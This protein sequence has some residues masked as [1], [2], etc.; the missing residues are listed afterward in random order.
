MIQSIAVIFIVAGLAYIWGSRGFFSS[1]LHMVCVI[2]A[3]AIAYGL[4]ETIA[5]A[6]LDA[7]VPWMVELAW[8]AGL[9]LPFAVSLAVLRLAVDKLV[10][11]NCDLDG[12]PNLIG[13]M[14]CG[15]ITGTITA[16][17]LLT[18]VNFF[19]INPTLMGFTQVRQEP[20][21]SPVINDR[22]LFP[23][24]KITAWVY[25]YAAEA[26]L[27]TETPLNKWRPNVTVDGALLRTNFNSGGSKHTLTTKSYS[28]ARRFT[29][30]KEA[31]IPVSDLLSD[32]FS[33]TPPKASTF[34]GEDIPV[35]S[36]DYYIDAFVIDFNSAAREKEG[37]VVIGNTQIQL[38]CYNEDED[39]S[40]S[41][42]PVAVSSKAEATDANDKRVFYGRWRFERPS[43]FIRSA[44]GTENAL[45]A[46]E[47]LVPKKYTPIALYVKGVREDLTTKGFPNMVDYAD[48]RARD[49]AIQLGEALGGEKGTPG[50]LSYGTRNMG[51][52]IIDPEKGDQT[53]RP[54]VLANTLPYN[55]GTGIVLSKDNIGSL[56][57]N[58]NNQ[59]S[60]GEA[61]YMLSHLK[62]NRTADAKLQV[63]QFY[64]GEG[65]QMVQ[66]SFGIN[67][68]L[69]P[70]LNQAAA[71]A[72]GDIVLVDSRGEK[73]PVIG[74]VYYDNQ[75]VHI[76][77]T[78][79]SVVRTAAELPMGGP[80]T[81]R[82]D[83]SFFL[84]FRVS[85]NT[86][87]KEMHIGET[88]IA[89]IRPEYLIK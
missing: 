17:V 74:F 67:S 46:F 22:L 71:A 2:V 77:Y 18:S 43:T 45:M 64:P 37:S 4:W 42:M 48:K 52:V 82:P 49:Q 75:L 55:K 47:F 7:G 53:A 51:P 86:K 3:G 35:G 39:K 25:G 20:N 50:V 63:R 19:R 36:T 88:K 8:G 23:A 81:S 6:I 44:G 73:Y 58:E 14:A 34:E 33:T 70:V 40:I 26:T 21:G 32:G 68:E 62:N 9:A 78:P 15:L 69:G 66:V 28:L 31:S 30:G 11:A 27:Y 60:G 1:F 56:Q 83:Q 41:I 85:R 72:T 57:L 38:V 12:A 5:Y 13:G 59:I 80:S 16:G 87:I 24:D 61:K 79:E 89:E 29:V 76:R 65:T 84:L 10:P 54:L